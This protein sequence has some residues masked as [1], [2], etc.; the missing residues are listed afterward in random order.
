MHR[1]N[2]LEMRRSYRLIAMAPGK[3]SVHIP[4]KPLAKGAASIHFD[5]FF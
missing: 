2:R 3:Y 5:N 1:C 4:D